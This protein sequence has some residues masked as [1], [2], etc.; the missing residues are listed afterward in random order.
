[1]YQNRI[2]IIGFLC[3][4]AIT[5]TANNG[6]FA[7]LC[8]ATRSSYTDKKTGEY[9]SHTEWHQC[10]VWGRLTEYAKSLTKGAHLFIEGELRSHESRTRRPTPSSAFGKCAC[11]RS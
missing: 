11:L 2:T 7:A 10:V 9:M 8:L 6:T 5:R 1:M 4:D 3:S